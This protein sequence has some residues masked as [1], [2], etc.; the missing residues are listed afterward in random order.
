[1][2]KKLFSLILT[3]ILISSLPATINAQQSDSDEATLGDF[4]D[5]LENH[6]IEANI[7]I[8]EGTQEYYDYAINQLMYDE[9]ETLKQ[10]PYYEEIMDY[11]SLYVV[12]YQQNLRISD[13]VNAT[14]EMNLTDEII[15]V[16]EI[17]ETTQ[18]NADFF[19]KT[20]GEASREAVLGGGSN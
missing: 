2:A 5:M 13:D 8:T 17:D 4:R 1:M 12:E 18:I 19:T 6:F 15:P 3:I 14:I 10:H 11:L 16:M 20:I 9:D 7:S